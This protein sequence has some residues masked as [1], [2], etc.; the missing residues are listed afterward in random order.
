MHYQL[1]VS[2]I[3]IISGRNIWAVILWSSGSVVAHHIHFTG[4][5]NVTLT[6]GHHEIWFIVQSFELGP[7]WECD[8]L[9]YCGTD[10]IDDFCIRD[11]YE[12]YVTLRQFHP[13]LHCPFW[14]ASH[15][16]LLL[17]VCIL[18][19]TILF[20]VLFHQSSIGTVATSVSH[21]LLCCTPLPLM[22]T[23]NWMFCAILQICL[24]L[25]HSI[26]VWEPNWWE[27]TADSWPQYCN[28]LMQPLFI[29]S[30]L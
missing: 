26:N 24:I 2:D 19:W 17:K 21:S 27:G 18:Q 14:S 13:Q 29:L 12:I 15:S 25:L 28:S 4:H 6:A 22:T 30:E 11:Y 7:V 3:S 10:Q 5:M 23:P 20:L 8:V 16:Y 1:V 9:L